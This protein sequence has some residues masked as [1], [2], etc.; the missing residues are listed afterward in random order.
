MSVRGDLSREKILKVSRRLFAAKGFSAVTMQEICDAAEL[1]RG[2]LY[3]HYSSTAQIFAAIIQAEQNAAFAA[4]ESAK[5]LRVPPDTI[6]Y[7]FLRSRMHQLLDP[8]CSIDNAT[9]EFAAGSEAGKALLTERA[10]NSV[11]ILTQLLE[12][13]LAQGVFSC[14]DCSA[15]ALHIILCLEGMGKHNALLPLTPEDT[16]AQLYLI[17]RLLHGESHPPSSNM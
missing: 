4:L 13:G 15:A 5:K 9:A 8:S 16:E 10:K 6:L 7:S 17:D 11:Q 12:V 2:G 1:S 14:E 3:R